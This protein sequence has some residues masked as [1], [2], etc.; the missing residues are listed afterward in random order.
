MAIKDK[1]III[2]NDMS[3][4]IGRKVEFST[5]RECFYQMML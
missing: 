4:A 1:T 5:P 3:T 2:E